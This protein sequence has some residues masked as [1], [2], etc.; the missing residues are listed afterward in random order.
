MLGNGVGACRQ[1]GGVQAGVG[2]LGQAGGGE[3]G[4]H[5]LLVHAHCRTKHAGADEGALHQG[6]QSLDGAVLALG[7]MQDRQPD[8][9][10]E[11]PLGKALETGAGQGGGQVRLAGETAGQHGT[12]HGLGPPAA[13]TIDVEKSRRIAVGI[14]PCPQGIQHGAG[15]ANRDGVFAGGSSEHQTDGQGSG[16]AGHGGRQAGDQ[17]PKGISVWGPG[18]GH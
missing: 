6:E 4:L 9:H 2:H 13:L 5:G 11:G 18:P 12:G 14:S 10:I 16:A 7:P 1:L 8:L 3:G 17:G 15:G